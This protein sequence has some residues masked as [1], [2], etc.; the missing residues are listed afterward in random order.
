VGGSSITTFV[1]I[2]NPSRSALRLLRGSTS[3]RAPM[4]L[5][6]RMAPLVT[7]TRTFG[8]FG[9]RFFDPRSRHLTSTTGAAEIGSWRT[10][11]MTLDANRQDSGVERCVFHLPLPSGR[12]VQPASTGWD[13]LESLPAMRTSRSG[14]SSAAFAIGPRE[15]SFRSTR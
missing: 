1:Q 6:P 3:L 8:A 12:R 15:L 9:P 2:H 10:D 4:G 5:A 13:W 7:I 11:Q 14:F